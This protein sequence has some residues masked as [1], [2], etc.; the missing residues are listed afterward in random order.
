MSSALS[1]EIDSLRDW[2][3]E[4]Q[5]N[6]YVETGENELKDS[7]ALLLRSDNQS[8]RENTRE[9]LTGLRYKYDQTVFS[10]IFVT[11]INSSG[12]LGDILV[13]TNIDWEGGP[14]AA[15][16][17]I[18]TADIETNAFFDL[19]GIAPDSLTFITS[20]PMR[21][22]NPDSADSVVVGVN[23]GSSVGALLDAMQVYWEQRGI[24]RVELGNTFLI[25]S[26]DVLIHMPRYA[27]TPLIQKGI[28]H[29]VVNTQP[30]G[31]GGTLE[32]TSTDGVDVLGAYQ[33][34]PELNIAVVVEL[35]QDQAFSGL[36]ELAL[37]TGGVILLATVLIALLVPIVTRRSLQPLGMLTD[38]AERVAGGDLQ[39]RVT[40]DRKDEIG[41]LAQSFNYMTNELAQFYSSLE[42]RVLQ[43]TK[44]IRLA[45]EMARDV[46]TSQDVNQLMQETLRL[47]SDRFT[48]YH[49]GIY[50][51]DETKR[52][53]ILRAATSEGGKR[54][55]NREHSLGVGRTGIV[56][57]VTEIGEPRVMQS[58]GD[59][60]HY[61]ANPDLP[62]TRSELTLPL[63]VSGS[64]IGALDIQS[65]IPN[66]FSDA[67]IL[68]L[69]IIADQLAVAIENARLLKRQYALAEQ[70]SKVI[71]LLN[72]LSQQT[73][74]DTLLQEIPNSVREI[75]NLSRVTLGLV[76]GENVVVRS[77]SSSEDE[78]LPPID[79]A[80][81]G[82][83]VLGLTVELKTTQEMTKEPLHDLETQ[84]PRQSKT[85]TILAIP[86]VIRDRVIG[87]LAFE[88]D[89]DSKITKDEIEALEIISAQVGIFIENARLLEDMQQNLDQMDSL[90]REQ[91]TSAWAQLLRREF[92]SDQPRV[93]Y[94]FPDV[95]AQLTDP[96]LKTDIELRGEVIGNLDLR[97]IRS[98]DWS[99]EDREILEAVADELATALEQARLM[100]E[101]N[102]R[103]AQLQTAA[104]IA[105]SA[106]ALMDL[107]DLLSGSVTLIQ[108]RF[109]FYHVSIFLLDD[110]AEFAILRQASGYEGIELMQQGHKLEV[111]S[112]S[113]I[114]LVTSRG[115]AYVANQTDIDPY[116]WP[117]PILTE[118]QSQLGI[119][120][121][122]G[123]N[124][125]GAI[126]VQHDQPDAFGEDDIS[127][128]QILADQVAVAVQNVRLFEQTLSRAEREKSV[129]EIT[130]RIRERRDVESMLQ[131]ALRELQDALGARAGRIRMVRDHENSDNP[132]GK[133]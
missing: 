77:H 107:D 76:E 43:R 11:T 19:E 103:V 112:K 51:L 102:R 93:E 13:S 122:I 128:L 64:I 9:M 39:H 33:W 56:G 99:E 10:D 5:T 75:F 118:T 16:S 108:D 130:S 40:L 4:R 117:N 124:V 125:L 105:R 89:A 6:L 97:G 88:S 31:E 70:R 91:T 49:I 50:L 113:I 28:D 17:A 115:N 14:I 30:T 26:P 121:K 104:E 133:P 78:L 119:P 126:D 85:E 90:H 45:A 25:M 48:Y 46:A 37:F 62:E 96:G 68:V 23:S 65:R 67:D 59:D 132:E 87:S 53:A 106:S 80:P 127:V 123:E 84:D 1:A 47:I 110:L 18:S 20:I 111:G 29:P 74:Y 42:A 41:R 35:S 116:Y 54:M 15:L 120:L 72:R 60:P 79:S 109:N 2:I 44:E 3:L 94:G 114:G 81:I 22:Q 73:D 82:E 36:G 100:E 69:Q 131:T 66:A 101:I 7:V 71:D 12:E 57:F 55:L 27:T 58:I 32:Y 129:V 38:F 21:A 63:T 95:A 52:N 92:E 98:G 8:A 61:Y 24:Y 86:L 83:G 34:L